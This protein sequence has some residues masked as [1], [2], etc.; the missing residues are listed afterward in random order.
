MKEKLKIRIGEMTITPIFDMPAWK[1]IEDKYDCTIND[2]LD[3]LD[4]KKRGWIDMT[5]GVLT[6]MCNRALELAGEEKRLD[7]ET[8]WRMIPAG[9][10]KPACLVCVTNIGI[11]MRTTH[12]SEDDG[13][14]DLVLREIEKKEEPAE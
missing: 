9:A 12:V 10:A 6:I 13:P 8:V 4:W 14:V 5:V 7:E 2:V 11:A 3:R 1:A